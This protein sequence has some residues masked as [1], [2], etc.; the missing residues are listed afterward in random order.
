MVW[1]YTLKK[2]I[3]PVTFKSTGC[4]I[5]RKIDAELFP[6][7]SPIIRF[8]GLPYELSALIDSF[9]RLENRRSFFNMRIQRMNHEV[10]LFPM[11]HSGNN[12][13]NNR[14]R[15]NFKM[16]Q[17]QYNSA[18]NA[19]KFFYYIEYELIEFAY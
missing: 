15:Y 18:S 17:F 12:F 8:E 6:N 7:L 5:N 16:Y 10:R 11:I 13:Y 19:R 9:N 4:K 2:A 14:K 1:V 3:E